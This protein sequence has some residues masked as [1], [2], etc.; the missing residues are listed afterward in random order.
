MSSYPGP[1]KD[2]RVYLLVELAFARDGIRK[3]FSFLIDKKMYK[4]SIFSF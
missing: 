2:V 1:K 3:V 4:G